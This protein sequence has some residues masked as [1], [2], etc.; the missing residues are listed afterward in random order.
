MKEV[1]KSVKETGEIAKIFL[2]EIL[3]KETKHQ[4]S[5]VI[6][7]VGD[8]GA[9]KTTFMQAI[10]KHLGVKDKVRSP[11]FVIMKKYPL[12]NKKYNFL[13]HLDAYRLKDEQE[14]LLLGWEEIINDKKN[15]VFIEWPENVSKII[16]YY[17]KFINISNNEDE[18]RLFELK[19]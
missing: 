14:L 17:A 10:A 19:R 7:L 8:L 6:G 11:T 18:H 16:P 3:R 12:K 4:G 1:S 9:G 13:F 2:K 15:L 5:T